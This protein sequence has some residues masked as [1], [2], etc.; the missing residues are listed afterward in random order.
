MRAVLYLIMALAVT[1]VAP[2]AGAADS[3]FSTLDLDRCQVILE[4]QGGVLLKC[5]GLEGYPVL[6]KEGD[7]RPSVF[8]GSLDKLTEQSGFESFSAFA[9]V[10][11]TVEWRTEGGKPFAAILRFFIANTDP[12]TGDTPPRL[13]GQ[14]LVVA[15]VGSE[16]N[17]TSCVVGLVDALANPKANELARK[18]ADEKAKDFACGA[19]DAAYEGRK[20]SL[21]S[22]FSS[23]LKGMGHQD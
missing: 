10:N 12:E 3:V 20:G 16:D 15:R 18:I 23:N 4:D 9:S 2:V 14:V 5:P 19:D 11:D 1:A 13:K 7:L 17:P 6:Y 22:D 8:Y 21:S